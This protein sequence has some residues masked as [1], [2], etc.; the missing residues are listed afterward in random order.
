MS[1][2]FS[3]I[4]QGLADAVERRAHLRWYQR[5]RVPHGRPL[6]IVL[7]AL[8]VATPAV[9][10]VAGWFSPGRPDATGPVSPGTLF[11]VVRRGD[12]RM[13]P[14][15]VADPQGGPPW[16]LRL[17]RTSRGD[18]CVELG[19]V[20]NGQLGSLG[21][22]DAWNNDHEFHAIPPSAPVAQDCGITDAAGHGYVNRGVL[23]ESA[24]ANLS[25]DFIKGPQASGCRL[26]V[27]GEDPSLPYCPGGTNRIV[28]YGLLG[29]DAVSVTYRK[30]GG[31]LATE[32]T[33][34][35]VGAY[36]LVFP[37]NAATCAEY[38]RTANSAVNCDGE[39]LDGA[40]PVVPGAVT[41]VTYT[42]GRRCS[43]TQPAGLEAAFRSFR[44]AAVAK[45]GR[46]R[47]GSSTSGRPAISARWLAEYR[48]LLGG[49]LAREHLTPARFRRELRPVPQCPPVGWV[50][51]KVPKVTAVEVASPV[52][53]REFP[54]GVYGC[55]N[56]LRL[57]DACDGITQEPSRELPVE[58]SFKARLPVTHDHSW[59][60]WS[61]Q[62]PSGC[63][64]GGESFATSSNIHA[65]QILR[66]STFLGTRCRGTYQLVVAFMAQAPQ[67]Q[68]SVNGGSGFPGHDGSIIVGRASFTIR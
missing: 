29:P 65:G 27:G 14:M 48:R 38:D 51:F 16:G 18:T 42:E 11:G 67:G 1:D 63:A 61:L 54:I 60:E 41:K 50:P 20:Q 36:L 66:Y 2:Y 39:S 57:P 43:L 4:R 49:F 19:R 32:R 3:T 17:V 35:G 15:R 45:L 5:L 9:A 6:A 59:Y 37:Y 21:I 44:R 23:G 24:S 33:V 7:A 47:V 56:K 58:W 68:T 62:Y 8:V 40:T 34:A 13:L 31:G 26:P 28:F 55:P 52:H 46:P 25:G 30:P 53:V 12:S 22:D 10:A 64:T